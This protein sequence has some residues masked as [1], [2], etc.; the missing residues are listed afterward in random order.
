MTNGAL[1]CVRQKVGFDP[2]GLLGVRPDAIW[3][4][5]D[6]NERGEHGA[7]PSR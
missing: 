3:A 5:Y 2:A 1:R 4:S 6:T 7:V